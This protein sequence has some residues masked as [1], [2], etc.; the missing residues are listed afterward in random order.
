MLTV[1]ATWSR[2]PEPAG[3][4]S[5]CSARFVGRPRLAATIVLTSAVACLGLVGYAL[6]S[7]LGLALLIA[8]VTGSSLVVADIVT[9]LAI[10]RA[11][12]GA[13]LGRVFGAIEGLAVSGTVL[14]ALRAS[15]ARRLNRTA[16]APAVLQPPPDPEH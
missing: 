5:A 1:T 14:G 7:S 8:V 9:A 6:T 10:T 13:V 16:P 11:A 2:L 4:S 12:A 15:A 3:C